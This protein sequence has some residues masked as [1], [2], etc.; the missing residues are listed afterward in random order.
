MQITF[1]R[2]IEVPD[3]QTRHFSEANPVDA[4]SREPL[5]SLWYGPSFPHPRAESVTRFS[6]AKD[7]LSRLVSMPSCRPPSLLR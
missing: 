2:E 5:A 1:G 4:P 6:I 7:Y 3:G